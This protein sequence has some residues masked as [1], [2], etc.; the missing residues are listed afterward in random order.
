MMVRGVVSQN[1]YM[2][3]TSPTRPADDD[4][5]RL[6]VYVGLVVC[7]GASPTLQ[8]YISIYEYIYVVASVHTLMR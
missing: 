8:H 3:K 1:S 6:A 2:M 7:R 4:P 5:Y